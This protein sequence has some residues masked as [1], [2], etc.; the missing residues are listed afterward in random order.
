MTVLMSISCLLFAAYKPNRAS[1]KK[2][3]RLFLR[4]RTN[5][6]GRRKVLETKSLEC[7]LKSISEPKGF[8]SSW[9]MLSPVHF[10]L[11][12]TG[13]S[14]PLSLSLWVFD[15]FDDDCEITTTSTHTPT[16]RQRVR[17]SGLLSI[18]VRGCRFRHF[19]YL[20]SSAALFCMHFTFIFS[21]DGSRTRF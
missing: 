7:L 18:N 8:R 6:V 10:P 9:L 2:K 14:S 1:R 3:F 20:H 15:W 13:N 11:L 5:L 21:L 12:S 4:T 16:H 17:V 19:C